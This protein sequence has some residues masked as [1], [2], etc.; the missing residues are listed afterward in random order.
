MQERHSQ[1]IEE[2]E[3]LLNSLVEAEHQILLWEKKFQLAKEMREATDALFEHGEIHD[4]KAEIRRMQVRY[5][6][7]LKQQEMLIRA[8]EMCVSHRETITTWAQ[9]QSKLEKKHDTKNDFQSRKQELKKKIMETQENIY[10][11]NQTKQEL[12]TFQETLSDTFSE[13]KQELSQLEAETDSLSVDMECLQKEKRWNLLELV[14]HQA[15]HK[16][17]QALRE[18]KYKTLCHTEEACTN[19]QEKLQGRLQ[20]INIIVQQIQEE[21]PQHQRALQWLRHSLESKLGL[22]KA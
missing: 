19:Q 8:M 15:H 10:E 4:M 5:G 16:Q 14:A 20:T 21:Q 1:L 11:C 7:L 17:L 13:K 9:A 6:Q 2:K 18:G 22:E 12:E 3:R